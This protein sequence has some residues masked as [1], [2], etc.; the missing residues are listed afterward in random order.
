MIPRDAIKRPQ[1]HIQQS[2]QGDEEHEKAEGR[3]S[4]SHDCC[5]ATRVAGPYLTNAGVGK[6]SPQ[7]KRKR[8]DSKKA[9]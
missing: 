4:T 3:I 2:R 1:R 7:E 8:S 5:R 6:G 9:S